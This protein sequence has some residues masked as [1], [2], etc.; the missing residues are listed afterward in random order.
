M[1]L[2]VKAT[3]ISLLIYK[4][5]ARSWSFCSLLVT[6]KQSNIKTSIRSQNNRFIRLFGPI[7]MDI[8]IWF[9]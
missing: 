8:L 9:C 5:L 7:F 4:N 2:R 1:T 6:T 3:L